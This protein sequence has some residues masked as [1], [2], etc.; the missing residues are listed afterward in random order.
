MS[1]P[2]LGTW[3]FTADEMEI[4]GLQTGDVLGPGVVGFA[5]DNDEHL[6]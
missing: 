2:I 3:E 4:M 5:T 6:T 1:R